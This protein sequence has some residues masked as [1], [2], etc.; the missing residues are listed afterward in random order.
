MQA[1]VDDMRRHVAAQEAKLESFNSQVASA[2]APLH[3]RWD[4]E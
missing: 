1:R 4:G 2:L 3:T